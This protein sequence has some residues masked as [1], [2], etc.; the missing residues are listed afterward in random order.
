[1]YVS[2]HIFF[3]YFNNTLSDKLKSYH[4]IVQKLLN[5][6]FPHNFEVHRYYTYIL[7]I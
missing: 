3:I 1:M 5:D 2:K 7:G 6:Y 4:K